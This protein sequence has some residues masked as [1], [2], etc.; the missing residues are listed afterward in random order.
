MPTNKTLPLR[1][2]TAKRDI[3]P[4]IGTPLS[5]FIARLEPSTGI[6]D[7]LHTRAVVLDDSRSVIVI[8]QMDLLGL[9]KWHVD[10]IRR[11]CWSNWQV[12]PERV[13]ISTTHTHSGPGVVPLRGCEVTSL[14]YQW[15]LI[16]R[17]MQAIEEAYER[18]S[19]ASIAI[20][21]EKF[22]LGI[23]RRQN[24]PNGV[25]LGIAPDKPAPDG[26]DVVCI[27]M[28]DAT[29]ILFSHAVHPYC[30]GGESTLIS[31]D[32]PSLACE[33]LESQNVVALFVNG[34][35]GNIAPEGAFQGID[36]AR[37]QGTRLAAAVKTAISQSL[38]ATDWKL[39]GASEHVYLPYASLPTK[40]KLDAMLAEEERVV[41]PEERTN[42]SVQQKISIAQKDWAEHL[43]KILDRE[44]PLDPVFCEVQTIAI[45]DFALVG[46]GGEPFF[47]IGQ[48]IAASS[49]YRHTWT[50]G[51]CNSYC[52][53]LPTR[54]EFPYGGYEVNDSYRYLDTW[55]L[56]SGCEERVIACAQRT[57][58]RA[59]AGQA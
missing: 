31:G 5:G 21:R 15:L 4:P 51:Y 59:L 38:E 19:E 55:Q 17:T 52:G 12:P 47:E 58:A 43:S 13:M 57:L 37:Q 39:S 33:L 48:Q 45:G 7:R 44:L 30:L 20:G 54:A 50:L 46:V 49:Q 3:T 24:T 42:S 41:R 11:L 6:A 40:A 2:G 36:V 26:V 16:D 27:R 32:I 9:G 1:A 25:V 34:C 29:A 53:Y 14:G 56:E 10:E 23:N 35:A 18:R 28:A 8:V 22:H